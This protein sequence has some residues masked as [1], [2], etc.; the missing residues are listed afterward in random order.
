MK[1]KIPQIK[2]RDEK[3]KDIAARTREEDLEILQKN[4]KEYYQMQKE[5]K[6]NYDTY[7]YLILNVSEIIKELKSLKK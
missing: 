6:S 5:D 3:L 2:F 4:L 7:A 1:K